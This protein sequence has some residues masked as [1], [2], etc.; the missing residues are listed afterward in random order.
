MRHA[1]GAALGFVWGV[2]VCAAAAAVILL[3]LGWRGIDY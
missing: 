3:L 2:V 1:I